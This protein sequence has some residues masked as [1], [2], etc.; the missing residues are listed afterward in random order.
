V[1]LVVL[2]TAGPASAAG[3]LSQT[4]SAASAVD[5]SCTGGE[6]SGAGVAQKRVTMP[7]G[8]EVVA[9]LT[10]AS[11]D[12]DL[13]IVDPSDHRLVAGSAYSGAREVASGFAAIGNSLV[14]QACRR[15]GS[16]S[17][18][19]LSVE[20]IPIDTSHA[21]KASLGRVQTANLDR[22]NQ[23]AGLGLD[24]TEHGGPG[25]VEAVLYGA[26]DAQTLVANNFAYTT[27]VP[28]LT[29][30]ARNDRAADA[31]FAAA[32]AASDLPSG[33]TTYRR[34]FDYSEDMKALVQAHPDLVRPITLNHQTY[35]GRP[36][37][38]VEIASNVNARDGRPTFL[39]LGV[40][41][42]ASGPRAS[43]PS[44]G[45]TSWS[46]VIRT[47]T[48]ASATS[49]R[50]RARSSSRSSTPTAS[51]RAARRASCTGTAAAT[52]PTL[53]A[54]ARSRI[55]SSSPRRPPTST[56]TAARTAASRSSTPPWPPATAW[57]SPTRA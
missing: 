12:W 15:S 27:Q 49:C 4:V 45:P 37:E 54:T 52:P 25:F 34:L 6:R 36:V 23:L 2:L 21:P 14:V 8:G 41:T 28:D 20:A 40:H 10:A 1:G 17:S 42:R 55:P 16:S 38:G 32:N 13:A 31:R 30:Q 39:Q 24:L 35:E 9:R 19:Q 53:T 48:P 51:T 44:S 33:Q 22:K 47:A 7:A 11:G 3:L 46:T 18:A 43:T 56:S 57:R 50:G 29:V 26:A 5:K